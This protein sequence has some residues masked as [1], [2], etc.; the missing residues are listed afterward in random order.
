MTRQSFSTV[1]PTVQLAVDSTSLGAYKKCPRYYQLSI[2]EGWE[3]RDQS[4]HL[5]FG[6][7]LHQARER[8]ERLRL[9]AA[10]HDEAL[11]AVFQ[12]AASETWNR[13]LGRPE[14]LWS[15]PGNKTRRTLLQTIVWF[16]DAKAK[17]DPFETL[18]LADGRP[19]VEL[20]FA[21]DSGFLAPTGER[22]VLCGHL[23]R[24]GKLNG[25]AYI[26]DIKTSKYDVSY[27]GWFDQFTPGNQFSMYTLAGRVAFGVPVRDLVVDGVQVGVGFARFERG[28]V[29]RSDETLAEWLADVGEWLVDMG[30]SATAGYWRMNDTSCDKYGGCDFRRVCSASPSARAHRLASDF[31]KRADGGWDPLRVREG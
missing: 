20:S 8:Y 29:H 27:S 9:N 7:A 25:A 6:I 21:F 26:I 17:D 19:A 24:I 3:P 15:Q 28:T 18:V 13:A 23:D 5:A 10:T 2:L 22:I 1:V 14:A 30:R 11:E 31:R 16:L 12:Q 4:I